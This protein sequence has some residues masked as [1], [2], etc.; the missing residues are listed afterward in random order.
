MT[1]TGPY[2]RTTRSRL[3]TATRLLCAVLCLT[4]FSAAPARAQGF[5]SPLIGYDFGGDARC[6]GIG[7]II[8]CEDTKLNIGVGFGVMGNVFGFEEEL[9]YASNFFGSAP[10]YDS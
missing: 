5:I 8:N 3:L 1:S 4:A 7:D 10:S 2:R 9:A 6:L